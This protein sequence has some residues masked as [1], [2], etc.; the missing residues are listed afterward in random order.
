MEDEPQT[1]E[2]P[3]V[4]EELEPE[5]ETNPFLI[6]ITRNL[7]K[8]SDSECK[9]EKVVPEV[10]VEAEV[11]PEMSEVTKKIVKYFTEFAKFKSYTQFKFLG[12]FAEEEIVAINEF[13][14]QAVKYVSQEPCPLASVFNKVAFEINEDCTGNTV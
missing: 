14:E 12:P 10:K 1:P 4:P 3:K 5:E 13:I 6:S 7:K 9:E 11:L 8:K 2:E